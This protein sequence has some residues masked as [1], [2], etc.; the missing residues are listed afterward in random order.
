MVK[1]PHGEPGTNGVKG[2]QGEPGD[3]GAHGSPGPPGEPGIP[4]APAGYHIVHHSQSNRAPVCRNGWK[5][6]W[7]GYSLLYI[8]G[9]DVSHGQDLG[10]SGSCLKRF[11]T[12]P[13]L[14]CNTL[15]QCHYASRNDYSYWLS[16]N[17]SVPM[18]PIQAPAVEPYISKCTVCEAPGPMM[19]VHSQAQSYP[20]CPLGW[21]ELWLGYS[22]LMVRS[23]THFMHVACSDCQEFV[24]CPRP[25]GG[26]SVKSIVQQGC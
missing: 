10:S 20:K 18:M 7:S 17:L 22:F 26:S 2:E 8:Q 6:L 14:F 5:K 4:A 12:I 9:H 1:G 21:T 25:T 23:C 15:G 13:Y 24:T 19:A 16:T 11:T 3:S